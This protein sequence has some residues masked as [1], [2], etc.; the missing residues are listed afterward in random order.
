MKV[1]KEEFQAKILQ[2]QKERNKKK[3]NEVI[4]YLSYNKYLRERGVR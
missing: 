4:G 3:E 2:L 1:S